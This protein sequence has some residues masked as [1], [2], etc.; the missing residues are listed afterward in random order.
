MYPEYFD[1]I[2][3]FK[4]FECHIE[5]GPKFKPRI[6]MPHKVALSIGPR[7]KKEVDQMEKQ[8]MINKPT[9]PIEWLK[10]LTK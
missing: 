5:L 9:G 8:G 3:V 6:Q 1:D 2:G 4:N 7:Q 10:N